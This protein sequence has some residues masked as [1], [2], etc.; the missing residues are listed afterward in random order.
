MAADRYAAQPA[1]A[2]TALYKAALAYNKQA[3]KADY[4]QSAAGQA[5]TA[6]KDFIALYPDDSRVPEAQKIIASLKAEQA[7]GNFS[8]AQYYEKNKRWDGA[9]VYYN[10]VVVGGPSSPLAEQA[11]RRIAAIKQRRPE[12]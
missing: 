9:L 1:V 8:I 10:A 5:T 7:R 4:D 11:R 6:F 2:S 12:K 3:R